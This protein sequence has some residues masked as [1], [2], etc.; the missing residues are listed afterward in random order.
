MTSDASASKSVKAK[1][2]PKPLVVVRCLVI[3]ICTMVTTAML[4]GLA[5][6]SSN[7]VLA[8]DSSAD[9]Q[10]RPSLIGYTGDGT[11]YFGRRTWGGKR[12]YL[13]WQKWGSYSAYGV[14][15]VWL[16]NCRPACYN[17]S[18]SSRKGW[19]QLGSPRNG[20]FIAMTITYRRGDRMVSDTRRIRHI[21]GSYGL[22][23]YWIWSIVNR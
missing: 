9:F 12:G 21:S 22:K 2:F 10:T 4:P 11:G 7:T 16:N 1:P 17:G 8:N 14:G 15:T 18:W 5:S 19:V 6:A 23:G 20:R 3:A 13:K